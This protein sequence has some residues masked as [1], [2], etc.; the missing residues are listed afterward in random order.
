MVLCG[1]A[2]PAAHAEDASPFLRQTATTQ[3]SVENKALAAQDRAAGRG[4]EDRPPRSGGGSTAWD[5]IKTALAL[6][7]VVAL[8][9]L[10]RYALRRVGAAAR[11]G[12]GGD[13]I[14]VLARTSVS[15]KQQLLLV[16]LA[17]RLVLVGSGPAGM[18]SLSEIREPQE[19]RDVLKALE[20]SRGGALAQL[21]RRRSRPADGGSR[22]ALDPARAQQVPGQTARDVTEKTRSQP[23]PQE[24]E[25]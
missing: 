21:F 8:I 4:L 9:F 19:V 22:D 11:T 14:E 3:S 15:P 7:L 5:W 17:D 10:V 23:A 13:V 25:K 1:P 24:E 16:R 18:A 2:L 12:G 6:A 20:T